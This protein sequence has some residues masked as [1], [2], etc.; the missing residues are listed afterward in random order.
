[1]ELQVGL[2]DLQNQK[3]HL[4]TFLQTHLKIVVSQDEDKLTVPSE[5]VSVQEL[6][7][8]VTK[9][10]YHQ[11]LNS[12]HWVSVDG[13]TVKINRFKGAD[14]KKEKSKKESPHQTAPQSWGL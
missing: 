1:M 5:K 9:F 8:V 2:G 12:T 7:H 3:E 13:S 4:T 6:Q 14:K 11:N 10:V